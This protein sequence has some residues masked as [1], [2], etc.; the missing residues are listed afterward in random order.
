[1]RSRPVEIIGRRGRPVEIVG[2]RGRP[3]LGQLGGGVG[4]L[5]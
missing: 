3:V 1:M 2:R 4:L 5:G